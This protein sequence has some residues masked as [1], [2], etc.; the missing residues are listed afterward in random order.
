MFK[1]RCDF[2]GCFSTSVFLLEPGVNGGSMLVGWTETPDGN[3]EFQLGA[4]ICCY[5]PACRNGGG[6]TAPGLAGLS[7]TSRYGSKA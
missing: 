7:G 6:G 1:V 3:R 2:M 4:S 5:C